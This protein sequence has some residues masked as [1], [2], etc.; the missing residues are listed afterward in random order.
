MANTDKFEMRQRFPKSDKG[1]RKSLKE[2]R[3]SL[4][5]SMAERFCWYPKAS[6]VFNVLLSARI[7]AAFL[8]NISDCDETFNYWEPTHYLMYGNGF[9]TWEYSPVY[10]IRSY[11]Y[12]LL[13][14][15][16]AEVMRNIF[17]ANKLVVF[18]YVRFILGVF[19]AACETYFYKAVVVQFGEHVARVL[20]V[21]L[22]FN[23]G[24]FISSTAFL[25]SSFAMCACTLAFGGWFNQNF[26]LAIFGIALGALVGWPFCAV[27]GLPIAY[28]III[29]RRR[30]W[31]FVEWSVGCFAAIMIPLVAVDTHYYGKQ[32]I[33][34][35]NIV[36]YN[37]FGQ[38]GPDLYGVEPWTFYFLNGFL[39][40][41]LILVDLFLGSKTKGSGF[42]IPA[43]LALSPMYIWFLVF[44][45]RP[46]KEERFL[47][48]V[49]PF[50]CL[51]GSVTL[52]LVQE[53]YHRIFTSTNKKHF[54]ISSNWLACTFLI[55]FS[56]LSVSRSRALYLGYH[57]PLDVYA[58]LFNDVLQEDEGHYPPFKI[59]DQVNVCVGK[60]WYRFPSS[61]FLP[62]DT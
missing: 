49:Y 39:N 23:T 56:S 12:L 15:I 22:I 11:A 20:F 25:P 24:M 40:F 37:I 13:H 43:W 62:S 31:L 10:A 2:D 16:P 38:G 19:S 58:D 35:L 6:V 29:R 41:N 33:A 32:V 1:L 27:L 53:M 36:L 46:H 34:P 30:L 18:Y 21:I 4:K 5:A 47:F 26:P 52:S 60:E 50:I 61:F 8:S 54:S 7:S 17:N 3:T 48:P 44:F 42:S 59:D 45:T 9:Q 51:A 28:D 57:A 14:V 55:V